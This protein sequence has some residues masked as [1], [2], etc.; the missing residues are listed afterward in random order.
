L[1][2]RETRLSYRVARALTSSLN[3]MQNCE[4]DT[5]MKPHQR[6]RSCFLILNTSC[7]KSLRLMMLYFSVMFSK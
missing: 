6:S 3:E 2:A 1:I 5:A 7:L 4:S